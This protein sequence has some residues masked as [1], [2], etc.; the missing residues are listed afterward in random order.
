MEL[1]RPTKYYS[2]LNVLTI[3]GDMYLQT[4]LLLVGTLQH[5]FDNVIIIINYDYYDSDGYEC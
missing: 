3:D 1:L 5:E 4:L 2:Y